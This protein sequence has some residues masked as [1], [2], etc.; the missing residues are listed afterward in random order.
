[1]TRRLTGLAE[2]VQLCTA[3]LPDLACL[4]V[5]RT[6]GKS[7]RSESRQIKSLIYAGTVSVYDSHRLG[8][9]IGIPRSHKSEA[10]V[11]SR[12]K[13]KVRKRRKFTF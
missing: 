13:R 12:K 10:I 8:D 3:G 1:M 5:Q 7:T 6:T 2:H 9:H 4:N 11:V